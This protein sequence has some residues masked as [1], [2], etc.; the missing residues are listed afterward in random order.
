M[1]S[2]GL[3][4]WLLMFVSV[5]KNIFLSTKLTQDFFFNFNRMYSYEFI[6]REDSY[7]AF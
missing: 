2:I 3:H 5:L 4:F 1:I 6:Q 7:N